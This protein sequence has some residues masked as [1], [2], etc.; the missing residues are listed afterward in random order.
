M[1][2][3]CFT[4]CFMQW[5]FSFHVSL[6]KPST[7]FR[8]H[9]VNIPSPI[10]PPWFSHW[11]NIWWEVQ[12]KK[13]VTM[14]HPLIFSHTH[15][16]KMY[17]SCRSLMHIIRKFEISLRVT[18]QWNG[19][20]WYKASIRNSFGNLSLQNV[21]VCDVDVQNGENAVTELQKEYGAD[22]VIFIKTDVTNVAELEGN[23]ETIWMFWTF[24]KW[25][26]QWFKEKGLFLI[27]VR[28]RACLSELCDREPLC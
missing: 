25:N 3:K 8:S 21:A 1:E 10:Q 26:Y 28:H 7:Y 9:M 24:L 20:I 4:Q 6:P 2:V 13:L 5:L 16:A 17:S 11:H 12:I 18:V 14:L 23:V 15:V 27:T 22:R 19:K